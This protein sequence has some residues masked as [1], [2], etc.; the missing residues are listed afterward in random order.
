MKIT[1]MSGAFA[2]V[3]AA[4][5]EDAIDAYIKESVIVMLKLYL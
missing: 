2:N 5:K 3:M 1:L 4:L